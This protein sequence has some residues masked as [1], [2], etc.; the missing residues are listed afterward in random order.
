MDLTTARNASYKLLNFLSQLSES[1]PKLYRSSIDKIKSIGEDCEAVS[2]I[3][4]SLLSKT[5]FTRSGI[6]T[7]ADAVRG[8][9][10]LRQFV[11]SL[12]ASDEFDYRDQK[13]KLESIYRACESTMSCISD[14]LGYEF[15]LTDDSSN[16]L[17]VESKLDE[18]IHILKGESHYSELFSESEHS[19]LS[20]NDLEVAASV[21]SPV[22]MPSISKEIT[23]E[24]R[25]AAK[26]KYCEF[27]NAFE[28]TNISNSVADRCKKLLCHWYRIRFMQAD[29]S[30]NYDMKQI[31]DWM[32]AIVMVF[33]SHVKDGT[34][35]AFITS[36]Y[37]WL[38]EVNDHGSKYS[39]PFEIFEPYKKKDSKLCTL[40]AAVI[41][42]I[43][44][45][46]G[47][48]L[49]CDRSPYKLYPAND[50]IYMWIADVDPDM[51]DD[52]VN[53]KYD[54]TVLTKLGLTKEVR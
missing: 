30:F 20:H 48:K 46:N 26:H 42:D 24:D 29:K 52:Y 6:H 50:T 38:E 36:F 23:R 7:T 21:E 13:Q 53:Y 4:N 12:S 35:E 37:D 43:L 14:M 45:D 39:V 18:I 34:E 31:P 25:K 19:E 9:F 54:N 17:S 22:S 40:Q 27:I 5:K 33:A 44:Y 15:E 11:C 10:K 3:A 2:E 47:L 1:E 49:I 28:K 51:L 32:A 41:W 8:A 16:K